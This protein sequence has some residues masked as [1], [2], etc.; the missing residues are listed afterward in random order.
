MLFVCACSDNPN[1]LKV[2]W[3]PTGLGSAALQIQNIGS[4]NVRIVSV[5]I[6]DKDDCF[7]TEK[8]MA[9]GLAALAVAGSATAIDPKNPPILRPTMALRGSP[10]VQTD[11]CCT[12][13]IIHP[14][15]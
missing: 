7:R 14:R 8:D 3:Q 13:R 9:T 12:W 15:C 1:D 11:P 2:T 5:R 4:T 6:N 10:L